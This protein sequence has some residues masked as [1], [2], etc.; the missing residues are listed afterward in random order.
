MTL[1]QAD[2][3]DRNNFADFLNRRKLT[4]AAAEVGVHRGDF[5]RIFLDNWKGNLL[6]LVDPWANPPG[7]EPQATLL[8]GGGGDR[9]ADESLCR[10]SLAAHKDRIVYVPVTSERAAR[11]FPDG[12]LDFVYVDGDHRT[13]E[14]RGDLARWWPKVKPGG[15]LAGHDVL[16]SEPYNAYEEVQPAVLDFAAQRNLDVY[17]VIEFQFQPWSFYLNKPK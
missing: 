16:S 4:G 15:I 12:V 3:V 11:S 8:S 9:D 5:S 10:V 6:Y 13:E 17:L 14:V 1:R 7:Y 2:F